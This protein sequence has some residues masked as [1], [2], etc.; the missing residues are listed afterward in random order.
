MPFKK[1]SVSVLV[2]HSGYFTGWYYNLI[3][4][5]KVLWN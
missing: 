3:F 2:Q 5:I 1:S 4:S